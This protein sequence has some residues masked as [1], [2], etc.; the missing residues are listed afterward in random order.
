MNLLSK[1]NVKEYEVEF[2]K[3]VIVARVYEEDGTYKIDS[4]YKPSKDYAIEFFLIGTMHDQCSEEYVLEDIESTIDYSDG[5]IMRIIKD[6][7]SGNMEFEPSDVCD[8][9]EELGLDD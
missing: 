6:I 8:L 2:E 7:Y 9:A 1:K 3:G 5:I 4:Y